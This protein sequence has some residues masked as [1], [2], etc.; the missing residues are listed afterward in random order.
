[1]GIFRHDSG[2]HNV[3]GVVVLVESVATI[4][5]TDEAEDLDAR[6]LHDD[7]RTCR[8]KAGTGAEEKPNA[9]FR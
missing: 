2:V 7:T 8:E 3:D 1:M 5:G 4:F 9:I 6:G